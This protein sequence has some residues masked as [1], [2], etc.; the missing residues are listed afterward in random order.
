MNPARACPSLKPVA[1]LLFSSLILFTF[2][3]PAQAQSWGKVSA[4]GFGSANNKDLS[5]GTTFYDGSNVYIYYGS[6]NAAAGAQV[7]R[8]STG[9][10]WNQ[11]NTSGFD[12]FGTDNAAVSWLGSFG[13]AIFSGVTKYQTQA[14]VYRSPTGAD[15]WTL[16]FSSATT[17]NTD[18]RGTECHALYKDWL[19]IGVNNANGGEIWRTTTGTGLD[20]WTQ[21]STTGFGIG[22]LNMDVNS[23][24][25][26]GSTIYAGLGSRLQTG[27]GQIW[28]STDGFTFSQILVASNTFSANTYSIYDLEYFN[29]YLY[30]AAVNSNGAQLW[31]SMDPASGGWT[32]LFTSDG[33]AT[34]RFSAAGHYYIQSLATHGGLLWAATLDATAVD[35]TR[36]YRS[37]DGTSFARYGAPG[38]GS[39]N[40]RA[41]TDFVSTGTF[42]Y[43]GIRNDTSGAA[44]WRSSS[45]LPTQPTL[46]GTA[47]GVSSI[48]WTWSSTGNAAGFRL[49][50]STA[51]NISGDLASTL[52]TFNE[53]AIWGTTLL[54]TNTAYTRYLAGFNELGASTSTGVT[55]YT[56]ST[57]PFG[58][59]FHNVGGSSVTLTWTPNSNP[60]GTTYQVGYWE[61]GGTEA[62]VS[63]TTETATIT[64][65]AGLTSYYFRIRSANGDSVYSGYDVTISS[66]TKEVLVANA[67]ATPGSATSMSI[68]TTAGV[69]NVTFPAGT[70]D[71]SA[72]DLTV[73]VPAA[74]PAA[75]AADTTL[76]GTSLGVEITV[77]GGLQPLVPVEISIPFRD[78]DLGG[79]NPTRLVIARY[80]TDRYVWVPLVS[81]VGN[82]RVSALTN[83]L[84][85]F[86]LMQSVPAEG[87][88]QVKVFPNPMKPNK[89]DAAMA[90]INLPADADLR[91]HTFRGELLR[92]FKSNNAGMASWDG[93]N[94]FGVPVG[95][96][97]YLVYIRGNGATRVIKAAI[98]R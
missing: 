49:L 14:R 41:V 6:S 84:S 96:G 7:W 89:G 35:G 15:P 90:F 69:I 38:F 97:V 12:G 78:A 40:N 26:V 64:Q 17:G 45:V 80:D 75:P 13:S 8:S 53:T 54:S 37:T 5:R 65:L 28:R 21:I 48:A 18:Y 91:V 25:T 83:H 2:S 20:Q 77:S 30:A 88:D 56:A 23:L 16:V 34:D 47:L 36:V 63:V 92:T 55:K 11:A 85:T 95:S 39:A 31:R 74:Y 68:N 29:G 52:L 70:F 43:S 50:N 98:Q 71:D 1:A 67:T 94:S 3:K 42:V 9:V 44:V 24:L 72:P 32:Q 76:T 22:S 46:S 19:Y 66:F 73:S 62:T 60:T 93:K 58:S 51:G 57:S 79:K 27:Q 81:S 59:A 86:Q 4:D 33:N 82:N 87:L 61:T 10:D